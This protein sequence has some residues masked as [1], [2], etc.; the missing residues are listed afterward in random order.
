MKKIFFLLLFAM[1]ALHSDQLLEKPLAVVITAYNC[2][3][4]CEQ[5]L[6]SIFAQDYSNFYVI[7][8]DDCSSDGTADRVQAYID[9]HNLKDRLFLIR[10]VERR[11]K[12]HN[13]YTVYHSI[14][15]DHIIIQIDGDDRLAYNNQIFKL[16]NETYHTED[17]W[18]TYG[19]YCNT[20]G[21]M[22]YAAP[23]PEKVL[24]RRGFRRWN[25]V[26]M[27]LRTFN[28]WLFKQ[29]KLHDV[30]TRGVPGFA[31]KFYPCSNDVATMIPMLEMAGTRFKFFDEVLYL[32]NYS[33]PMSGF[34]VD[35]GLQIAGTAEIQSRSKYHELE[36]P[37]VGWL[38]RL[39]KD[40]TDIL[41]LM[42]DEKNLEAIIFRLL[43]AIP[44]V[45]T[46]FVLADD[47]LVANIEYYN[48]SVVCYSFQNPHVQ[49]TEMLKK[50]ACTHVVCISDATIPS[51]PVDIK[52]GI[53]WLEQTGAYCFNFGLNKA[54]LYAQAGRIIPVQYIE[55]EIYAWKFLFTKELPSIGYN[56]ACSLY[57]K[58][59]LIKRFEKVEFN[60]VEELEN[61]SK[62]GPFDE[63]VVGLFQQ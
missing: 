15:D 43:E 29:I 34:R 47:E 2:A 7:F 13:I 24:K 26:Y 60:T 38:E 3:Q 27:H 5:S 17:V 42:H 8:V 45:G 12:M 21:D 14:P 49:L 18:L 59:D 53:R 10:N 16:I 37:R 58:T 44:S 31:G 50:S 40:K 4:W 28:A 39:S 61:A 32:R 48:Q 9:K 35:A 23:V 52:K 22:G 56:C 1:S 25:F 51:N 57:R 63:H 62:Y 41:L 19:Q 6:D 46:I 11:R 36:K 30:I 20:N 54:K 33:N 55:D